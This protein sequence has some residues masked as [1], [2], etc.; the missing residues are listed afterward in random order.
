MN[1]Y[2]NHIN[3]VDNHINTWKS[4]TTYEYHV[5]KHM[6]IIETYEN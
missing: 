1:A 3:T 6:K 4:L 5:N 2:E